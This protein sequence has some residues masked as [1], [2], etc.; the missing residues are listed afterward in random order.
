MKRISVVQQSDYSV[1]MN[2]KQNYSISHKSTPW[3]NKYCDITS[4]GQ[5]VNYFLVIVIVWLN[6]NSLVKMLVELKKLVT[7]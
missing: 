4:D 5:L 7:K 6:F 3:V 1:N 2:T